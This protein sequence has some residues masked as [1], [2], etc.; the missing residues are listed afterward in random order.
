MRLVH[1]NIVWIVVDRSWLPWTGFPLIFAIKIRSEGIAGTVLGAR[2]QARSMRP[3]CVPRI[4]CFMFLVCFRR[5]SGS[6]KTP[7]PSIII[8]TPPNLRLVFN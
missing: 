1:S 2:C 3:G 8:L 4:P 7:S 5:S 6:G